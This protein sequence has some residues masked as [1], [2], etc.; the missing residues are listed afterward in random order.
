[1]TVVRIPDELYLWSI[2]KCIPTANMH[3]IAEYALITALNARFCKCK[4]EGAKKRLFEAL[5]RGNWNVKR[6]TF[7]EKVNE[8]RARD[9]VAMLSPAQKQAIIDAINEV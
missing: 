9:L 1:M 3:D 7:Q 5:E 4:S 2:N 6:A 8:M